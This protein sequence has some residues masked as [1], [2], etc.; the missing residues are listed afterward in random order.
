MKLAKI[1]GIALGLFLSIGMLAP[2][3]H[4]DLANQ[5]TRLTFNQ[6]VQIPGH[7]VLPA[8]TYW[9][10]I[11]DTT[12]ASPNVVVIYNAGRT[13]V[14][15]V[16]LARTTYKP[17]AIGKTELT[18]AKGTH[19]NPAVLEKWFYPDMEYGHAFVYSPRTERRLHE[20]HAQN[21]I[22]NAQSSVG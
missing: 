11:L 22:V 2:V 7:K 19:H 18:V 3:A 12:G 1:L 4:A 17:K 13:Q 5:M 6:P 10:R 9:F 20:E 16:E 21:I 15:A 8:G 14:E